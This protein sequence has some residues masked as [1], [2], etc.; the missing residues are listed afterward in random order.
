MYIAKDDHRPFQGRQAGGEFRARVEDVLPQNEDGP[1]EGD[2]VGACME[3]S[4]MSPTVVYLD[5]RSLTRDCVGRWLQASLTGFNVCLLESP[6]RIETVPADSKQ[7]RA[8]ILNTGPYRMSS[9]MVADMLSRVR[10]LLPA[11]PLAVLSDYEDM[12]NIR[13]AFELE[14]R[15]YIPTNLASMVAIGAVHLVC[16]GGTFAPAAPLLAQSNGQH[17]SRRELLVEGFTQRQSQILDCLRRGM[18]NKLI[19]YELK[20]CESTVK[21]H[22]RNIMKKLKATN[23]TQVAYMTSGLF[24]G[25]TQYRHSTLHEPLIS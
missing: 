17:H 21:V 1:G 6:D 13:E 15:G 2:E 12:E 18:A 8:V 20:M 25:V 22:I 7:I 9:P 11:V 5:P 16:V 14:I 10:D 19:A 24:E 4:G 23:R 3:T